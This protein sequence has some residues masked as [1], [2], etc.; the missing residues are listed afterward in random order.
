MSS[1]QANEE[2]ELASHHGKHMIAARPKYP[3]YAIAQV[4]ALLDPLNADGNQSSNNYSITQEARVFALCYLTKFTLSETA[5]QLKVR[6]GI[7][8]ALEAIKDFPLFLRRNGRMQERLHDATKYSS[9]PFLASALSQREFVDEEKAFIVYRAS[10][11]F[12]RDDTAAACRE[13]LGKHYFPLGISEVLRRCRRDQTKLRIIKEI[14]QI[15]P[16]YQAPPPEN[17][18]TEPTDLQLV[19]KTTITEEQKAHWALHRHYGARTFEYFWEELEHTTEFK[20][21]ETGERSTKQFH[22]RLSTVNGLAEQWVQRA[23]V[24]PWWREDTRRPEESSKAQDRLKSQIEARQRIAA[25]K[26]EVERFISMPQEDIPHAAR[27]Q[28]IM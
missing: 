23:R 3:S 28:L 11:S 27:E 17:T 10:R 19:D 4:D 1:L 22:Q 12:S 7:P 25:K 20:R 21:T 24:Y 5:D 14:A 6:F 2:A 13:H 15:Y 26:L 16:W 9:Y 18:P 8:Q